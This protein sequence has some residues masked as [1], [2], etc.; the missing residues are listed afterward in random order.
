M[1]YGYRGGHISAIEESH[2]ASGAWSRGNVVL[3]AYGQWHGT[4]EVA[5][6]WMDMG[7]M[8][9]NDGLHFRE[10]IPDFQLISRGEKGSWESGSIWGVAFMNVGDK[11]F[12]YYCGLDAGGASASGRGDIGIALLDRDRFGY[13]S[14]KK[15]EE[16]GEFTSAPV[17]L[18]EGARLFANV[19]EVSTDS[20]IRIGLVDE[21]N[22]PI[23]GYS[24]NESKPLIESGL[25]QPVAWKDG[26]V[27]RGLGNRRAYL[28]AELRGIG[29][30]NPRLYAIYLDT[31]Q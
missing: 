3:S 11:T 25:R 28:K 22:Q 10:P 4:P 31:A 9:S 20:N 15:T 5:T 14:L 2:T 8:I 6:R 12:I 16:L 17:E 30:R 29:S 13:L 23:A 27:I 1:R 26:A 21:R 7:F 19:G 18:G 24:L